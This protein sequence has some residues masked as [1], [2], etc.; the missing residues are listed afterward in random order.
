MPII[1]F[2]N[3]AIIEEN[4]L[5]LSLLDI[6]LK[7]DIPLMHVC[8]GNARCSTCRIIIQEGIENT[9]PKNPIEQKLA[10][11]KGFEN[12]IRLACQTYIKGNITAR[13]LVIDDHDVALAK[14]Q[15]QNDVGREK[16]LAV[17]FSDI[18]GFTHFSEKHLP[19]DVIHVLNRYFQAMGE[20][21]LVH[22]GHIDKYIGDGLMALFGVT[23]NNPTTNCLNAVSCALQMLQSLDKVN[24]YLQQNFDE[25][26]EIGIGIHFGEVVLGNIGHRDNV[27]FTAIG[28]TVN[29]ASRIEEE[30][31]RVNTPILVS[32][33]LYAQIKH[34]I[35]IGKTLNTK[36][37]GKSGEYKLYEVQG[38][39]S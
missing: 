33:N 15:H 23:E 17:L 6:A 29:I 9:L 21:V 30:T 19:Y 5:N 39:T 1:T 16:Q 13:R 4:D 32:E 11:K 7:H 12:N 36:L 8:G 24:Q 28:D 35:R 34:Q 26:F 31:K 10:E 22:Q 38:L 37:K 3:D 25:R 20:A 18:R 27:Q 2:K 14:N